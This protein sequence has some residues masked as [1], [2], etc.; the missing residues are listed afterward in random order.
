ME[1]Y[2]KLSRVNES[3]TVSENG[4]SSKSQTNKRSL[5]RKSCFALLAAG[6]ILSGANNRIEAQTVIKDDSIKPYVNFLENNN[7]LSAKEYV[8]SKFETYDIV[9]LS[10]RLHQD[11]TQYDVILDVVKDKR[12]KGHIY[13]ETG[14]VNL[15]EKFNKFLLNSSFTKEE[16]ERELL[17]IYRD[18]CPSFVW[19]AYSYYHLLS[20]VWEI[21]KNRKTEDKILIFP[22]DFLFD[23]SEMQT[24]RE[25]AIHSRFI[26]QKYFHQRYR[27]QII[28][29]NFVKFYETV[30]K[31]RGKALVILNSYHGYTRI[32][33]YLPLP[34]RPF[35][36]SAGEFIY[37]TYPD[38]TFNIY[39]NSFNTDNYKLSANG[40]ID[41]AFE[42]TNK[43]NV[44]F[45]LKGTPVGNTKFD[46]MSFCDWF[47]GQYDTNI[48][49]DYI[50]DGMIFYK[51]VREIV[52]KVGIPNI[53]SKEYEDLLH[54]RV[55][56]IFNKTLEND[57]EF[58]DEL[59]E[60]LN[61]QPYEIPLEYIFDL[62][63]WNKQIKNW[64][65]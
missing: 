41:A 26:N 15:S 37:K 44:G 35:I 59:L 10:E 14:H 49:Y 62:E 6:V 55:A 33:T 47:G 32:P 46:L 60:D 61:R 23:Y 63:L 36:H 31:E 13:T 12:F 51:P 24:H 39:I 54:K 43:T 2:I 27:D 53:Y 38:K 40:I 57:K 11:M 64:I 7:F 56:L 45:D 48:N 42:Y 4:T 25:F 19:G 50:F 21:N 17:N 16:K 29:W 20:E 30:K 1:K 18:L 34:T 9:I 5:L 65:E 52:F 28:G 8:L 22:T 3:E 58:F